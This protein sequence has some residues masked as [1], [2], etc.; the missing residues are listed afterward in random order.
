MSLADLVSTGNS[1]NHES[2]AFKEVE[3]EQ[4]ENERTLPEATHKLRF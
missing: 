4:V 2:I 3:I 1:I